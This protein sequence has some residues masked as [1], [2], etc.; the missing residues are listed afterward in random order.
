MLPPQKQHPADR[1][2]LLQMSAPDNALA[3]ANAGAALDVEAAAA[4][5]ADAE[6]EYEADADADEE[7]AAVEPATATATAA[8]AATAA[9]AADEEEEEDLS[10]EPDAESDGKP[11]K[12]AA[13]ELK[14]SMD[15]VEESI[16]YV[17]KMIQDQIDL[18]ARHRSKMVDHTV[19][20]V[21]EVEV[22]KQEVQRKAREQAVRN[23]EAERRRQIAQCLG[24]IR[25]GADRLY[26]RIKSLLAQTPV[27]SVCHVFKAFDFPNLARH[28]FDQH[29]YRGSHPG[30]EGAEALFFKAAKTELFACMCE[31]S[32]A[33]V[34]VHSVRTTVA[35]LQQRAA[36]VEADVEAMA[37]SEL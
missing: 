16:D 29:F 7:A 6:E 3:G 32:S 2:A 18:I 17:K 14:T 33:S 37:A 13:V 22:S 10:Q 8:T 24:L 35:T 4:L 11:N 28:G 31:V 30:S 23:H 27:D 21:Q 36:E 34:S 9:P 12:A 19:K 15:E 5:G 26:F 25:G 20:S 1:I